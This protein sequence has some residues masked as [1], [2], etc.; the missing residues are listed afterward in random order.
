VAQQVSLVVG[1]VTMLAVVTALGRT[2]SL[3]EFGVYGLMISIPTYLLFAQGSVETIAVRAIAH[4]DEQRDRDRAFT[5][6]LALYAVFGVVAALLI[7]FGGTALLGVFKIAP[8][9]H[10][11]AQLALVALGVVNLAGWP[12]KT[13]QDLLRGSGCFVLSAAA[14]A[15]GYVTGGVLLLAALLLSAPLW[16]I[17]ALGGAISLLIGLWAG[18]A[19]LLSRLPTRLRPSTLSWSYARSFASAS[20]V[21]LFSGIS[22]LLIY[23]IDRTILGIFR[24]AATVGLYEGPVRAHNLVRQLQGT[25]T[26]I[27]MPAAAVYVAAGDRVRLQELLL[28][29]TRYVALAM[30]PFTIVFMVLSGPILE[31]WLGPRFLPAAGAMTILVSYWLLLG[32]SSVGLSMMIAAGR[33]RPVVLYSVAVAVLNLAVSLAL[34]PSLGLDGVVIGTSLPYALLVPVFSLLVCRTFAVPIALFVREGFMLAYAAG[35]ALAGAELLARAVL[36]IERPLVLLAA[37]AVGLSVYALAVY[38]IG[39]RS[40]ERLLVRTTLAGARRRLVSLPGE[41]AVALPGRST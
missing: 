33:L 10:G 17:V 34:T 39:L 37:I 12:V 36:P 8:A 29:G 32:G 22:D 15:L 2:L 31:V 14:E 3:S 19:I 5:T 11:Q 35:A 41:I 30:M 7:V 4:A 23:S 18:G 27:V 6:A 20:L 28:R 21:L 40:R 16:L 9:L 38:R 25:M 13:A 26:V 1:I 24:P